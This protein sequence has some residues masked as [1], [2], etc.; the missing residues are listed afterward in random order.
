VRLGGSGLVSEGSAGFEWGAELA[1]LAAFGQ[2]VGG[3]FGAAVRGA[4]R[5]APLASGVVPPDLE[6]YRLYA[7]LRR[8][9]YRRWLF[10]EVEPEV[11]WPWDDVVARELALAPPPGGGFAGIAT[12][13]DGPRGR[14]PVWGVTL[15]VEVQ[16]HGEEAA[17]PPPPPPPPEPADPP[18]AG[19]PP[20][21]GSRR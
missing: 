12:P 5:P 20:G 21:E 4:S 18:P 1:L 15:R 17:P 8:D 3:Q 2:R 19:A 6:R 11:A 9:F 16:F 14:H 10:L 7:R 13:L